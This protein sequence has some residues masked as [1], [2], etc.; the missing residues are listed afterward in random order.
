MSETLISKRIYKQNV[1][2]QQESEVKALQDV[3]RMFELYERSM[4]NLAF[5]ILNDPWDA[6]DAVI[7]AFTR[8]LKSRE[9]ISRPEDPKTRNRLMQATKQTS[10]DIYRKRRRDRNYV[11][12][13]EL[14]NDIPDSQTGQD[15]SFWTEELLRSLPEKYSS[16]LKYRFIQDQSIAETARI[17]GISEAAVSKRQER[18][19]QMLK[20]RGLSH[21]V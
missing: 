5:Q 14:T 4:Y 18:A 2:I 19:I 15:T 21:E 20:K 8:I 17:L 10:I 6:E 13:N 7:D 1:L 3:E 16:V 9:P 11:I 12:E